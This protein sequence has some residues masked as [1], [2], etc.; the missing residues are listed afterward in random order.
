M[1][2]VLKIVGC[3]AVSALTNQLCK[4]MEAEDFTR[5]VLVMAFTTLYWEL[6][7]RLKETT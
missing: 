7:L 3:I 1:R 4:A 2:P 5:G 6:V